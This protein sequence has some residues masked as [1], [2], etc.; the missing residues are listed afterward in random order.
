MPIA[1]ATFSGVS[2]TK[3]SAISETGPCCPIDT[4][5]MRSSSIG[6][7]VSLLFYYEIHWFRD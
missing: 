7:K 6:Q 2:T 3:I 5:V 4:F 1:V